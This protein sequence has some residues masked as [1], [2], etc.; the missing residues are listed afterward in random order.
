MTQAKG[1]RSSGPGGQGPAQGGPAGTFVTEAVVLRL[2]DHGEADRIVT[3]LTAS[4][5]KVTA[6]APGARRSR[7]RFGAA[8]APFGTGEASLRERR[9]QELLLLESLHS[10]RG[11]PRLSQELGRF[12]HA[13][14]ACEL[15]LHLCPPGEPEPAVL[16]LLR[17]YLGYLDALPLSEK[18]RVEPLRSFE[19][20]LLQAVGLGL[21]LQRCCACGRGQ[22]EPPEG[23]VLERDDDDAARPYPFDV[24]RGGVLCEACC[25]R[26]AGG[27]VLSRPLSPVVLVALQALARRWPVQETAAGIEVAP[28][29]SPAV[30]QGC[31]EVTLAVLRHH[32]GRDLRAVEF[33]HKLNL[34]GVA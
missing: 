26:A 20:R 30:A 16:A 25:G 4:H 8:L 22:A 1:A 14:Y 10:D 23:A 5:G 17:G 21:S 2:T 12:S 13:A 24:Q 27:A 31:R 34:T 28:R 19:L 18:P 3:L 29:L 9:G 6:V 11:F 33:I 15:C 32:L 7:R